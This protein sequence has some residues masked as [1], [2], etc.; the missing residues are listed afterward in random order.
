MNKLNKYINKVLNKLIEEKRF[1][2]PW[3]ETLSEYEFIEAWR[4]NLLTPKQVK[5][6]TDKVVK[7]GK[8]EWSFSIM[9][10]DEKMIRVQLFDEDDQ[11]CMTD[12]YEMYESTHDGSD[13]SVLKDLSETMECFWD[14][15]DTTDEEM[16]VIIGL[17][18]ELN[19]TFVK[20]D[21]AY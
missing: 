14:L 13:F 21:D 2:M 5:K 20:D 6:F 8:I 11:S 9:G 3:Y 4:D 19:A 15:N 16:Q 10:D 1:K 12:F 17:M 18:A 7:A